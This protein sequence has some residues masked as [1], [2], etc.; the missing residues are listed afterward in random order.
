MSQGSDGRNSS[1]ALAAGDSHVKK[2]TSP[3][4]PGGGLHFKVLLISHYWEFSVLKK[5]Q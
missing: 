4:G 2:Y 3:P 1:P 5:L